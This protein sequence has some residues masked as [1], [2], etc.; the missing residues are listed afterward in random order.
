MPT[1]AS[2]WIGRGKAE[3][4]GIIKFKN[5][6]GILDQVKPLTVHVKDNEAQKDSDLFPGHRDS[7]WQIP[8]SLP[9]DSSII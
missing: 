3:L 6:M 4:E 5:E 1:C 7:G 9:G 2:L 8:A